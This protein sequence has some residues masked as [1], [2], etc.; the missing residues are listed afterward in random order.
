MDRN[1]TAS[2]KHAHVCSPTHLSSCRFGKKGKKSEELASQ[3]GIKEA[4]YLSDTVSLQSLSTLPQN[5]L[6]R[7]LIS[8]DLK[9]GL[10]FTYLTS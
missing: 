9:I 1:H 3:M 6:R 5:L 2:H 7:G 4:L 10:T 8:Q